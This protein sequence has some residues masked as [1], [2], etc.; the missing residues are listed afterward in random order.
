MSK[1]GRT[2]L[3]SLRGV[4][5]GRLYKVV[6]KV[7]SVMD[8]IKVYSITETNDLIYCGAALMTE[9]L[10]VNSNNKRKGKEPWWKR[11]LEGQVKGLNRDLGLVNALIEKKTVKKQH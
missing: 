11:R 2:R 1:G 4:E 8:K 3:P 5:K 6:K 7:D 9:M 10:G